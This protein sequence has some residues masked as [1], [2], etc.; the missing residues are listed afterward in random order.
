MGFEIFL[1]N[2]AFAA[3]FLFM[4]DVLGFLIFLERVE[5]FEKV[6]SLGWHGIVQRNVDVESAWS[7]E[8]IIKSVRIIRGSE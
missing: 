1:I 6:G 5:M 3:S 8:S 4:L 2:E 7:L